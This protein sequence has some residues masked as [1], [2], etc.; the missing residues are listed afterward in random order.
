MDTKIRRKESYRN[1]KIRQDRRD[2]L[3]W[4]KLNPKQTNRTP[5]KTNKQKSNRPTNPTNHHSSTFLPQKWDQKPELEGKQVKF[6]PLANEAS[7]NAD[8]SGLTPVPVMQWDALPELLSS[9][10]IKAELKE[11]L[12]DFLHLNTWDTACHSISFGCLFMTTLSWA[13]ELRGRKKCHGTTHSSTDYCHH[14]A[15]IASPL[16]K[17][18]YQTIYYVIK[19]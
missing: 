11:C 18:N 9:H 19:Y 12:N 16:I 5:H 1:E 4:N 14:V 8:S 2:H 17:Q 3:K 10:G 7:F 13:R 15:E 6:I